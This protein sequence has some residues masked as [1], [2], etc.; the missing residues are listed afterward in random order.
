MEVWPASRDLWR[1]SETWFCA[2]LR[3][4]MFWERESTFAA[5][6]AESLRKADSDM[7]S[8]ITKPTRASRTTNKTVS[9]IV[10]PLKDISIIIFSEC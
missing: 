9:D 4:S 8:Q 10:F 7:P 5:W 3:A 2:V 1:V 6:P